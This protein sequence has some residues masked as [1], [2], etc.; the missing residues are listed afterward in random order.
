M[1][2]GYRGTAMINA[3]VLWS[4]WVEWKFYVILLPLLALAFSA[5]GS[6]WGRWLIPLALLASGLAFHYSEVTALQKINYSIFACGM[7]ALLLRSTR[8]APVM[9]GMPAA[10]A[11]SA[12]LILS[13][14][15]QPDP[16]YPLALA[17]YMLFFTCVICGNRFGGLLSIKGA[18]V[19]GEA[20][21]SIYM[22]HG[23][24]LNVVFVSGADIMA[25]IPVEARPWLL[26]A[27]IPLMSGISVLT[28]LLIERPGISL[29]RR[30]T[31]RW[32]QPRQNKADVSSEV[33]AP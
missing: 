23:I 25:A 26:V 11:G 2:F 3:F 14:T 21:F 16:S 9:S 32:S 7:L 10:L 1:L 18:L 29:G 15:L 13:M 30:L 20:S 22:L 31:R 24:L 5:I 17:A 19:L 28:Y 12:A 6:K 27:L 33:A 8:I 4:L